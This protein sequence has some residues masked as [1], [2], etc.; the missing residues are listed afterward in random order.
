MTTTDRGAAA[1]PV[2]THKTD[3]KW[4]GQSIRRVED[5]KFLRG[6]GGY[7][8]DMT[9]PGMLHA[10]V[11]RSPHAHARITRIDTTAALAAPGIHAVI[12]GAQAAELCGPLPDFGPDPAKHTWRCLALNKVR[13]VGEGV[14]VAVADS[15]YLAEDALALIEV[16]YE[17]LPVLV[18][19]EQALLEGAP[20]VHEDLGSNCAYERT[21]QFGEVDRDFAE[22]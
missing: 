12:T 22:A 2:R 5:P 18:D 6:R 3:R 15:R 16:D 21:F 13:Y 20:L 9:L 8:G 4:V 10:A 7:I 14:A 11:L 17:P 1:P 19:P